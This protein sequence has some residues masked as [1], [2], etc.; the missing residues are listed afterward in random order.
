MAS[1][2]L[3]LNQGPIDCRVSIDGI[4]RATRPFEGF[5]SH[6][7]PVHVLAMQCVLPHDI[8]GV[9]Q[10]ARGIRRHLGGTD[11]RLGGLLLSSHAKGGAEE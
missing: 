8:D 1:R 6:G 11:L 3:Q 2:I 10:E 4:K 7:I 5:C 9:V